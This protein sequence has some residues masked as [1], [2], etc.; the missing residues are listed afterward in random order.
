M[1]S[2]TVLLALLIPLTAGAQITF[3]RTYGGSSGDEGYSVQ[4]TSDGGYIVAGWTGLYGTGSD[5][6]ILIKTD[7]AG[8]TVW[9]RSY[10]GSED[11][12]GYS[13]DQTGDGGYV[14]AGWT[15]SFGAGMRDVYLIKTD[16]AGNAVLVRTYGAQEHEVGHSVE[17]TL[18]GG[19]VVAGYTHSFGAGDNDVYLIK[20]D[21][22]GDTVWTRAYGGPL[23]EKGYSVEQT[24]DEG[25]IVAGDTYSF[26]SGG[27]DVYLIK[28]DDQGDT[29]WTRTYGGPQHD[30]GFSVE[31]TSDGGYV[32]AGYTESFGSG[33]ADVYL[34]KTDGAG[35][36]VWTRTYGGSGWETGSSVAETDGGGYVIVGR[37]N[38][39]GE[40]GELYLI[41]TD[42]T[43][44]MVWT[45][46]Y[47]DTLYEA[48]YAVEQTGDGGYV[49][50]GEATSFG[51]G[52]SDVYLVK[53]DADVLVQVSE[54]PDETPRPECHY[55]V[56]NYP[57]PFRTRT[58][59]TYA[60]PDQQA[61]TLAIYD[62]RGALVREL[63]SGAVSA[64]SHR[65]TWDGRDGRGRPVG[66]GVYFCRLDAGEFTQ[67][68]R[69][70]LLR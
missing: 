11:E 41:K 13:V 40:G 65:V 66:S 60:L 29:V 59:I 48:G 5:D 9:V 46:T 49:I 4:Q 27:T 45:R 8:D 51:T 20:T 7:E 57:N 15:S 61:V 18:D 25:Y 36:T 39:F 32:I 34:I 56:Q 53:T 24:L 69:M 62:V 42:G 2:I 19:Y 47:G 23:A 6:V 17:Q 58:A 1:R 14:I 10:G 22:G 44:E 52:E 38:S 50:S 33:Q 30:V 54:D 43:G 31:Q 63:V 70:V 64:G 16:G 26:G 12:L 67:T 55:L 35:D 28:T 21:S 37:T 3:E 68:R